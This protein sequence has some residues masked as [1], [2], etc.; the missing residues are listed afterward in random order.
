MLS[1]VCKLYYLKQ[2]LVGTAG[3]LVRDFELSEELYDEAW[4][5]VLSRYNNKRATVRVLF[6]RLQQLESIMSN[7]KIRSL[8]DQVDIVIR[9]LKS[10]RETIDPTFSRYICY[11][12]STRLDKTTVTDWE[13]SISS[14]KSFP[15]YQEMHTFLAN[16]SFAVK[17]RKSETGNKEIPKK[18]IERKSFT[19]AKTGCVVCDNEHFLNQCSTFK[20]KKAQARFD[21]VKK[22]RLCLGCFSP[23]HSSAQCNSKYHCLCGKN[24]HALLHFKFKSIKKEENNP[25]SKSDPGLGKVKDPTIAST[26]VEHRSTCLAM[27][28]PYCS[29]QLLRISAAGCYME[30]VGRCLISVL[31]PR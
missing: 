30:N 17:D 25:P 7:T 26:K 5:F 11:H 2:A 23:E 21:I 6:R 22:N 29:R 18:Q 20:E 13:N 31:N 15:T 10:I 12:V 16:C 19:T 3:D 8:I 1:K 27:K 9:G 24:H 14:T 28:K 4:A